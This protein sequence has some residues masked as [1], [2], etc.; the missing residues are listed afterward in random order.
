MNNS[1]AGLAVG[2]QDGVVAVA[3]GPG[4]RCPHTGA[5]PSTLAALSVSRTNTDL[6]RV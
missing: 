4:R 3:R 5:G 1:V 2:K 6:G